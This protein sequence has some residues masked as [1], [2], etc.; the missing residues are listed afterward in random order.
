LEIAAVA[1]ETVAVVAAAAGVNA[2]VMWQTAA[3]AVAVEKFAAVT[4]PWIFGAAEMKTVVVTRR[5]AAAS[6]VVAA[7]ENMKEQQLQALLAAFALAI[8]VG[9][10]YSALTL[11]DHLE[12]TQG[13]GDSQMRAMVI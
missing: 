12:I 6:A 4:N 11:I 7:E 10:E 8:A 3:D 1:A 2:V 9:Q 13:V 5:L